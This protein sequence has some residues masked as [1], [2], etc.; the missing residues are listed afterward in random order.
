MCSIWGTHL[1]IW[2][3]WLPFWQNKSDGKVKLTFSTFIVGGLI[4]GKKKKRKR[5]KNKYHEDQVQALSLN[6]IELCNNWEMNL[7]KYMRK[8]QKINRFYTAV[9]V[10]TVIYLSVTMFGSE[11]YFSELFY[12]PCV[13]QFVSCCKAILG[14]TKQLI[15][16]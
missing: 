8:E 4:A 14:S 9:A 16:N 5:K 6:L 2:L 3:V 10:Y 13:L 7:N 12:C 1:T 15:S 11:I